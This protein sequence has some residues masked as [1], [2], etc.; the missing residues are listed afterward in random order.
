MFNLGSFWSQV[1][2]TEP[3]SVLSYL[4]IQRRNQDEDNFS[5]TKPEQKAKKSFRPSVVLA[6]PDAKSVVLNVFGVFVEKLGHIKT[7]VL[8]RF[9]QLAILSMHKNPFFNDEMI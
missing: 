8:R 3:T 7:L 6:Q 5:G 2:L 4:G 9:L 1:K